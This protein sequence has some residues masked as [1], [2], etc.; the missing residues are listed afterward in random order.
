MIDT[1][2]LTE[3]EKD[4]NKAI[5]DEFLT[6]EEGRLQGMLDLRNFLRI[7]VKATT[8]NTIT[9]KYLPNKGVKLIESIC[10]YHIQEQETVVKE[11]KEMVE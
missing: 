6:Y 10:R 3:G 8:S 7:Y 5:A 2:R 9:A 4:Y 1:D 11:M